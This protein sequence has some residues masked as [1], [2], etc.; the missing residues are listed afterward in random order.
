MVDSAR[1]LNA[2]ESV[3]E[4]MRQT[5]LFWNLSLPRKGR[6]S[7]GW[8]QIN[9]MLLAAKEKDMTRPWLLISD[10][11]RGLLATL[12]SAV[13]D[14]RDP[15]DWADTPHCPDHWGDTLRYLVAESLTHAIKITKVTGL[16]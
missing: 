5:N 3:I 4:I 12:P 9:S 15:D 14:E 16:S 11:C 8:A 7:S 6:R 10:K 13:R 1:G 2:Q